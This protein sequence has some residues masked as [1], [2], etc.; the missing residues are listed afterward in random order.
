[1]SVGRSTCRRRNTCARTG[2][3]TVVG[4]W[5]EKRAA[6]LQGIVWCG[7]C[8]RKM[9]IQHHATKEKR[10]ATYICQQ[11]HQQD[12][13]DTICQTMTARPADAAV[14]QAFLEAVSPV[15]GEVAVRVLS[16]VE[17]QLQDLRRQWELQ[18]QQPGYE[19]RLAQRRYDAVDPDSRLC[20]AEPERARNT[21]V[22]W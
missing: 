17:Q 22:A 13:E 5:L 8:G 7:H 3:G 14:V 10:S 20:A 6:L 1:M 21:R 4:V 2:S 11:G 18:L 15:G 9:G 16:Q 19:A 12:G